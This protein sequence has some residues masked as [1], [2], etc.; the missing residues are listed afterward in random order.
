MFSKRALIGV[1]SAVTA[2]TATSV[3]I[4]S[5][6]AGAPS[7]SL[8]LP[9]TLKLVSAP[10]GVLRLNASHE[11]VTSELAK[12]SGR[13]LGSGVFTCA[14]SASNSRVLNCK[15]AFALVDG[16]ILEH[17]TIDENTG[18]VTGSVTGGS[19]KYAGVSGDVQGNGRRDNSTLLV[20][21]YIHNH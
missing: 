12:P 14:I 18:R 7:T 19:G 9:T 20:L 1:A 5:A 17:E 10:T 11:T 4:A 3:A 8:Q 2:A 21:T 16:V 13:K 15:S 6:A